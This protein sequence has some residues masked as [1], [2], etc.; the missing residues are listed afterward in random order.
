MLQPPLES[1]P[2]GR[3][4]GGAEPLGS[5]PVF[6]CNFKVL[7]EPNLFNEDLTTTVTEGYP[8]LLLLTES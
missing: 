1:A 2:D 3:V 5:A 4:E 8:N 6:Y 7:E